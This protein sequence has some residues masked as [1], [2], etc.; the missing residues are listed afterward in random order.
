[1]DP[2]KSGVA[3]INVNC[4]PGKPYIVQAQ[5]GEELQVG[6]GQE[7]ELHCQSQGG[8][9]PAEIHWWDTDTGDRIVANMK[10]RIFQ[11]LAKY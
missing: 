1:M 6:A 10:G 3:S 2:V 9:P 5:E 11:C 8:K 4:E 7:V